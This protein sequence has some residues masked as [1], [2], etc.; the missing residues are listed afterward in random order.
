MTMEDILKLQHMQNVLGSSPANVPPPQPQGYN[1]PMPNV[2]LNQFGPGP[3]QVNMGVTL[4]TSIGDLNV[5][6]SYSPYGKR[7]TFG[8]RNEF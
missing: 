8:L 6:G 5:Q 1:G 3:P 7:M 2:S 4:P